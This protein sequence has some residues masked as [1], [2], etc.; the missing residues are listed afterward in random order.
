MIR[1][2]NVDL[3]KEEKIQREKEG[4]RE[5]QRRFQ[6]KSRLYTNLARLP[7][8]NER[9]KQLILI[10]DPNIFDS[11]TNQYIRSLLENSI[12]SII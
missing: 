8:I 2:G 10:I 1:S 7:T 6:E 5:R 3:T 4:N 11:L 12:P 9:I